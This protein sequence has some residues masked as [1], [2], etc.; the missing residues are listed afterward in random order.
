MPFSVQCLPEPTSI[1]DLLG[2]RHYACP[3]GRRSHTRQIVFAPYPNSRFCNSNTCL[4]PTSIREQSTLH[5]EPKFRQVLSRLY[6][7]RDTPT[8]P[9][10]VEPSKQKIPSSSHVLN[11]DERKSTV[12]LKI[13]ST[14]RL[15]WG[16]QD[17][18]RFKSHVMLFRN[19]RYFTGVR[20]FQE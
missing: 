20:T 8:N 14:L 15:T 11:F 12:D 1:R 4:F 19:S 5:S 9:P 3:T 7:A 18:C 16:T 6:R 13:T 17:L 10:L 2:V